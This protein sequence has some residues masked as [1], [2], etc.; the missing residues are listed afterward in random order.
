[1]NQWDNKGEGC[2]SLSV[3]IYPSAS[4][5]QQK[6]MTDISQRSSISLTLKTKV[7]DEF[8]CTV[9]SAKQQHA[10][11][12]TGDVHSGGMVYMR[13]NN[14]LVSFS[15]F[16]LKKRRLPDQVQLLC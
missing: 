14:I 5:A 4:L 7:G 10:I 9:I 1:M 8:L 6:F 11:G 16:D 15:W 13:E 3:A 12:V 2:K